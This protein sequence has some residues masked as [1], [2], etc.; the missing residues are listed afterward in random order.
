MPANNDLNLTQFYETNFTINF[1]L[2]TIGMHTGKGN[3][4]LCLKAS[5]YTNIEFI[6]LHHFKTIFW[7]LLCTVKRSIAKTQIVVN[8]M[9]R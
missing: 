1:I 2:L 3:S 8:S 5:M 4:V 6:A 9:P 7:I